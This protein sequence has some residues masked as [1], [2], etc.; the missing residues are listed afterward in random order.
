MF[1]I[2][3][4]NKVLQK[5]HMNANL[6]LK[7]RQWQFSLSEEIP[8]QLNISSLGAYIINL[9]GLVVKLK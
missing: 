2:Q 9:N 5:L 7:D 1:Y 8:H 6:L 4:S 3:S